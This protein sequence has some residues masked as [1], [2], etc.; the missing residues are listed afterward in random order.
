MT[1]SSSLTM[2]AATPL[3]GARIIAP[4]IAPCQWTDRIF[5]STSHFILEWRHV[6]GG[7]DERLERERPLLARA[8]ELWRQKCRQSTFRL[9]A[10]AQYEFGGIVPRSSSV[11]LL[12]LLVP[13][14][15]CTLFPSSPPFCR[16]FCQPHNGPEGQRACAREPKHVG[17][18]ELL[19]NR[20]VH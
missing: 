19:Y 5:V 16:S 13:L 14:P 18:R 8:G 11:S 10:D 3:A 15:F 4:P 1:S 7:V 12:L 2:H 6:L 17:M 20:Y 9:F